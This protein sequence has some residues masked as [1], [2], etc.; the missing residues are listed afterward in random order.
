MTGVFH[1]IFRFNKPAFTARRMCGLFALLAALAMVV[2]PLS[3]IGGT[4]HA[5]M[6]AASTATGMSHCTAQSGYGDH[7]GEQNPEKPA[8]DGDCV[9]VC[10]AACTALA[11]NFSGPPLSI[12]KAVEAVETTPV[13]M[14]SGQAIEFE[15][16]PPRTS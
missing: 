7:Q 5:E 6:M 16:P 12:H 4:A 15:P 14:L 1:P 9:A 3:I 10:L 13:P 2:A 11:A 8:P